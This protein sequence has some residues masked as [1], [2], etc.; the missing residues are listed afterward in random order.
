MLEEDARRRRWIT[1]TL[2][3]LAIIPALAAV[4]VFMFGRS[5]VE[6]TQKVVMQETRNIEDKVSERVTAS[7]AN[8]LKDVREVLPDLQAAARSVPLVQE[9]QRALSE[10]RS[11]VDSVLQQQDALAQSLERS[12]M[13]LDARLDQAEK[14]QMVQTERMTSAIA[15][16]QTDIRSTKKELEARMARM[17]SGS[18]DN[19]RLEGAVN[20]LSRQVAAI[21]KRLLALERMR[22]GSGSAHVLKEVQAINQRLNSIGATISGLDARLKRLEKPPLRVITPHVIR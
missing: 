6:Q 19:R 2:V 7:V 20:T 1:R 4:L 14:G 17:P 10:Y 22:E 16:M 12:A 8:E 13:H 21:N 5:D 9:N 11:Q 18:S 15:S 3:L